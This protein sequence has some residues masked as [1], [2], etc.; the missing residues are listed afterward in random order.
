MDVSVLLDID[1]L[2]VRNSR[3]VEGG[4]SSDG[5]MGPKRVSIVM[6]RVS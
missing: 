5:G 3:I 4:E 2:R 6:G 1:R